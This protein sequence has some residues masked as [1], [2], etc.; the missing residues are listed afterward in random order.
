MATSTLR[1]IYPTSKLRSSHIDRTEGAVT[2]EEE[3][4]AVEAAE[5][6]VEEAEAMAEGAEATAVEAVAED[7]AAAEAADATNTRN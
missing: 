5:D 3:G 6:T 2:A 7:M 4:T 1:T